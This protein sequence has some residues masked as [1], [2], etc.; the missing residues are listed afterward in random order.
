M[1]LGFGDSLKSSV[2]QCNVGKRSPILLCILLPG[3][4]ESSHVELEFEE[5]D[6]VVFSV[7]GPRS[8]Y[9]SGYYVQN[10]QSNGRS[11]TYPLLMFLAIFLENESFV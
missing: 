8:I 11:D 4:T 2:L 7:I 5:A 10:R 1:T 9:L 3:K 6:D